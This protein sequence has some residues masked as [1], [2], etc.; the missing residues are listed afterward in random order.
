[1]PRW[2]REGAL[3]AF[4]AEV[5]LAS[6][7]GIAITTIQFAFLSMDLAAKQHTQIVI[8]IQHDTPR[9]LL[10]GFLPRAGGYNL[11][12]TLDAML[13]KMCD[14]GQHLFRGNRLHFLNTLTSVEFLL[15]SSYSECVYWP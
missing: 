3:A 6:C 11:N 2:T 13:D 12:T 8:N 9:L 1:M 5:V 7:R 4:I 10:C 15:N 14:G